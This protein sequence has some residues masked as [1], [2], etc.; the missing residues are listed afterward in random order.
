MNLGA[1]LKDRT[2]FITG[3]SS[4]IGAHLA[5]TS[6]GC[7][8]NVVVAARRL[9]DLRAMGKGLLAKGAAG[10]LSLHLDVADEASVKA[11]IAAARAKFGGLDVVVNNAGV[12][13]GSMAIDMKTVDFDTIIATNLRGA[14][15]VASEA[16]RAFMADK[17][18][19]SIINIASVL[20]FRQA[21]GV[22]AYAM[23]KAGVVQM[24]KTLALEW[25]RYNIRVNGIA[26]GYFDTAINEG[27]FDTD[28]GKAM[29]K[30]IPMRRIGDLSDLDGPFLLLATEAS[31]FMTG[32]VIPV[33][34]GHLVNSL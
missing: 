6:A 22:A 23:S 30:R 16:A 34:G 5:A 2:V 14:F 4:G 8:A 12:A 33:D 20:G 32:A 17:R 26:P 28:A 29:I 18:G 24:T 1:L 7:G 9:G 11:A 10:V 27:F 19:G 15:M 3:A 31:R 25:A 13:G 21:A